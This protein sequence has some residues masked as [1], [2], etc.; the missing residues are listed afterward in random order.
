MSKNL[1]EVGCGRHDATPEMKQPTDVTKI[2]LVDA[3][4]IGCP[5]NRSATADNREASP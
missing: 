4:Y 1:T 5:K 2:V 3:L